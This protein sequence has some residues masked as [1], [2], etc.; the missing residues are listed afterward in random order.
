M[1]KE[2]LVWTFAKLNDGEEAEA[3]KENVKT[4]K[5]PCK[6]TYHHIFP[7]DTNL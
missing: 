1:V 7:S 5:D 2:H 4:L 6:Y 3:G